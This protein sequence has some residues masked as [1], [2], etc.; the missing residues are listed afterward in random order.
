M[1]AGMR[2]PASTAQVAGATLIAGLVALVAFQGRQLLV[3]VGGLFPNQLPP[4]P[5]FVPEHGLLLYLGTGTMVAASVVMLLTPGIFLVLAAGG[6]R[7]IG[8]FVLKSFGAA[9]ALRVLAH[10]AVLGTVAERLT[11]NRFAAIELALDVPLA[12]LAIWRAS[13]GRV[14]WP[15]SAPED[16]RRLAVAVLMPAVLVTLLLP[17]FFWQDLTSDGMEALEIGYSLTFNSWP[18][19]P[20]SLGVGSVA[21]GMTAMAPPVHWFVQLIGPIEAAA[22]LPFALYL[23][24]LYAVLVELIEWNAPRRLRLG[25]EGVLVLA[26]ATYTVAMSFN[27]TYDP[28]S[29]D[30]ASPGTAFETLTAVCIAATILYVWQQKLIWLLLFVVIGMLSRPTELVTLMA[31][32]VGVVLTGR[33][34][35]A[36]QLRYIG[37]GVAAG[38][39]VLLLHDVV[40]VKYVAGINAHS[41][42]QIQRWRYLTFTDATRLLYAAI[43]GGVLPFL[44]LALWRWQDRESRHLTIVSVLYFVMFYVQ[45]FVA[46]HHFVPVM[47]L[48]IVVFW[49]TTMR[50]GHVWPVPLAAAVTAVSLWLSLPRRFG[51]DRTARQVGCRTAYLAGG[52]YMESWAAHRATQRARRGLEM[53]FNVEESAFPERDLWLAPGPIHYY[54]AQCRTDPATAQYVVLPETSPAPRGAVRVAGNEEIS[55]YVRDTTAWQRDLHN[56]P[57]TD[58]RSPLFATRR[59]TLHRSVGAARGNYDVDMSKVPLL[60]RFFQRGS[61]VRRSSWR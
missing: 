38:I 29:A 4:N 41:L 37:Y 12:L 33:E 34:G 6:E 46:M 58:W 27:S 55:V 15:L 32:A 40:W 5:Y 11:I 22:R 10:A 43:P 8:A 39:A 52:D 25:E 59:E 13:R 16:R 18:R 61:R 57:P 51:V 47:L 30:I 31:L 54:A 14:Q 42:G 48:P 7:R 56:P 17:L 44:S 3:R 49:R 36:A 21:A 9:Y 2:P 35:R 19:F 20:N 45:A 26:L 24:V 1:H 28:Y 50:A 60:W 23:P 53:L